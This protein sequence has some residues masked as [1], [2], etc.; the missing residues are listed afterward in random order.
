MGIIFKE[1]PGGLELRD[2]RVGPGNFNE[3]SGPGR[4]HPTLF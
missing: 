4:C 3:V 1:L 2:G